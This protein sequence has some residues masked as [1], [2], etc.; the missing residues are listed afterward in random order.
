MSKPKLAK[1]IIEKYP[2]LT[3]ENV[4]ESISKKDKTAEEWIDKFGKVSEMK[5][6]IQCEID[7]IV[8]EKSL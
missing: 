7:K 6:K 4:L 2:N 5:A 1:Q 3:Y 8:S